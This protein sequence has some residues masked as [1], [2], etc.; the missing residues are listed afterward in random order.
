MGQV[1]D[2]LKSGFHYCMHGCG[3]YKGV[4]Q[5][6]SLEALNLWYTKGVRCFE[7][8]ISE[9]SDGRYVA[10]HGLD[11]KSLSRMEISNPPVSCEYPWFIRQRLFSM[12]TEGLTPL[13]LDGLMNFLESHP[14]VCFMLDLFPIN[15]QPMLEGFLN[16][17]DTLMTGKRNLRERILL[18]AYDTYM[19]DIIHGHAYKI[20][21]SV[22]NEK[23]LDSPAVSINYLNN[24]GIEFISYPWMYENT[25]QGELKSYTEKGIYAFSKTVFN[26]KKKKLKDNGVT[27]NIVSYQFHGTKTLYEFPVYIINCGKRLITKFK[28]KSGG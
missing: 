1:I 7:I 12:T 18:E 19:V 4:R 11:R 17:L 21:Y 14:D 25:F 24:H 27:V 22:R 8:D 26:T 28:M 15:C 6:N 2:N 9:T 3:A 20:I 16:A 10:S 5:T 23:N 13:D